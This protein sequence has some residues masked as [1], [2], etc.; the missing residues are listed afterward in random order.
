MMMNLNTIV[1]GYSNILMSTFL[2]PIHIN[3][4]WILT[5]IMNQYKIGFQEMKKD[6]RLQN[7]SKRRLLSTL[8]RLLSAVIIL[9]WTS[10]C[11]SVKESEPVEEKAE[12]IETDVA[13]VSEAKATI[14]ANK[15]KRIE[16]INKG[17]ER[18]ERFEPLILSL[19][20]FHEYSQEL[21]LAD[22]S[23]F[24]KELPHIASISTYI[25]K[26][27]FIRLGTA[28]G[29]STK[30]V[31]SEAE[32]GEEANKYAKKLKTENA[33]LQKKI[34]SKVED[35]TTAIA[36]KFFYLGGL[37][38]VGSIFSSF[39]FIAPVSASMK[40]GGLGLLAVG[41]LIMAFGTFIDFVR[42]FLHEYGNYLLLLLIIPLIL[43]FVGRKTD[44]AI[45]EIKDN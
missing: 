6:N 11:L 30:K 17:A 34:D 27:E 9:S 41:G 7:G 3:I 31:I 16:L 1:N 36:E 35:K 32:K 24:I 22:V 25:E 21:T 23:P 19:I 39:S 42:D 20:A 5:P 14:E 29:I 10:S 40:K 4:I 44:K 37:L 33:E 13:D 18:A 2:L 26:E 8:V 15:D 12:Y 43:L 38:F 28:D 45:D